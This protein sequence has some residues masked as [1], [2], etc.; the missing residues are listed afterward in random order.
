MRGAIGLLV[1]LLAVL[2]GGFAR[3]GH[4]L[5]AAH[6]FDNVAR[7]SDAELDRLRGGF[8]V[9]MNGSEFLMPFSIDSIERVTQINGQTYV[10]GELSTATLNPLALIPIGD[11][12]L[13]DSVVTSAGAANT[14]V[15]LHGQ[16]LVIQN[17][18]VDSVA[19]ALNIP[20]ESLGTLIQNSANDQVIR[21]FTT[22]NITFDA[23]L[24]AAQARLSNMVNDSL[25]GLQ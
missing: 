21:N 1:L 20:A 14:M 22:L 24:L 5:D 12:G 13:G 19:S 9:D 16:M 15:S 23:D 17:G 25:R 10:D 11:A 4:S 7:A 18:P 2:T 6:P 8:V 3:A